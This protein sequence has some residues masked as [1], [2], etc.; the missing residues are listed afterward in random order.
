MMIKEFN[1][2]IYE[3]FGIKSWEELKKGPVKAKAVIPYAD[4]KFQT[5]SGKYEF[6]SEKALE[7]FG[8]ALPKYL[9][10]RKPYDK[11]R[12]TSP[13]SRWSLHSQFQNLEWM[14]ELHPEPYVYINPDDAKAKMVEEG[15]TVAV[16][17]KQGLLRLKVKLTDNVQSGT[18]LMYEQWYNNNIYN[19]NELVDDTSSDMGAFK[20][21]APGVAL[22]DTF[23]NFRKI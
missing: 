5:P 19:V 2:G 7:L 8:S 9:E 21:G 18:V 15:D 1:P 23:V 6:Y 20:T 10:V 22:H 11:F 17:N 14:E 4:G 3:Q 12:M 13:H 16:F